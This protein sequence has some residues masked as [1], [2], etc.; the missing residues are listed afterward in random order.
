MNDQDA[1]KIVLMVLFWPVF[2]V[3]WAYR[4]ITNQV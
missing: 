3:L 4:K 1:K 2:L